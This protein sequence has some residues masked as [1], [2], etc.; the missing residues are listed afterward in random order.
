MKRAAHPEKNGDYGE[1]MVKKRKTYTCEDCSATFTQKY[2]VERHIRSVHTKDFPYPCEDCDHGFRSKDRLE[3]H[4]QN[5]HQTFNCKFCSISVKGLNELK[6]HVKQHHEKESYTCEECAQSFTRKDRLENH[7]ENKH[8]DMICEFCGLIVKGKGELQKHVKQQH[9][10][11]EK[12][13]T[14][15]EHSQIEDPPRSSEESDSDEN[16]SE[17]S[18]FNKKLIDKTW[19]IRMKKD[20]LTLLRDYKEHMKRYIT[21]RL[22]KSPIKC[23][24]VIYITFVKKDKDGGEP[25]KLETYF[26]SCTKTVLRSTEINAFLEQ[27]NEKIETSFDQF[28]KRGSGW[29]LETIDYLKISG[30]EFAPMRGKSYI[31][32]PVSIK[33]KHA[34][35]NIQNEDNRC[36]EYAI[37]ASQHYQDIDDQNKATRP[38]QYTKW[39][40]KYNFD[41]CSMPMEIND[42]NKFEKN[43]NMSINVYHIEHDGKMIT[44]LRISQQEKKLEEYINLLLIEAEDRCHYTWIRNFNRLLCYDIKNPKKFCPF[45][46]SPFDPRYKKKLEEHLPL[47][48]K[49]GGQKVIIPS[50]GKNIIQFRDIHKW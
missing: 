27:A 10:K 16:T 1:T 50:K 19:R 2:N 26:R 41:G 3:T 17:E 6:K 47:C 49:Y 9:K 5:N 20:P 24:I 25:I 15:V 14:R 22:I 34:I 11:E 48:R 38:G 29:I 37:I 31:P 43:N 7:M 18:A 44:P 12:I 32:T 45:C 28:L 8:Q 42:I 35:V 30:A 46:L 21:S 23:Y 33:G 4:I 36:F 13:L 39:L 40:G